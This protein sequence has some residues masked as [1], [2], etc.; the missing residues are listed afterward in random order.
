MDTGSAYRNQH[1]IIGG[2][3]DGSCN[4][5]SDK[6]AVVAKVSNNTFQLE[7]EYYIIK[8]LYQTADGPQYLGMSSS[9]SIFLTCIVD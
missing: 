4:R 7:R 1:R 2:T 6:M 8:Q 5:V 3:N 9:T